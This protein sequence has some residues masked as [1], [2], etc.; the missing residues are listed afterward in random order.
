MDIN[1]IKFPA[2]KGSGIFDSVAEEAAK[3]IKNNNK[4]SRTQL[5]KFYDELIMWNERVQS[6]K[7]KKEK[8]SELE[9]FIKMLK[10]KVAYAKGRNHVDEQFQQI[11]NR[12]IDQIQ[13]FQTL[14]HAKLFMEALTGYLRA[15]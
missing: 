12:C 6:S 9:P 2:E 3:A 13:D 8:F 10:A 15:L 4:N 14:Q 5:R 7:N 1:K 11:F